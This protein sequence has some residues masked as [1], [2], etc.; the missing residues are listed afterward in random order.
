MNKIIFAIMLIF[1]SFIGGGFYNKYSAMNKFSVP[2]DYSKLDNIRIDYKFKNK[3]FE[4]NSSHYKVIDLTQ[5]VYSDS[6]KNIYDVFNTYNFK[7]YSHTIESFALYMFVEIRLNNM[8]EYGNCR[9]KGFFTI[10]VDIENNKTTLFCKNYQGE[11]FSQNIFL[12]T[13]QKNLV[14]YKVILEN[15]LNSIKN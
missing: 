14:L 15:Y 7:K 13:D 9:K 12:V 3:I 11:D 5:K 2:I 1:F 6:K 8:S 4:I 10:I